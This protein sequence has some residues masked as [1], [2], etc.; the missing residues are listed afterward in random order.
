M[1][2]TGDTAMTFETLTADEYPLIPS[3][4]GWSVQFA[5]EDLLAAINTVK[6]AAEKGGS[7]PTLNSILFELSQ[8]DGVSFGKIVAADGF[9]LVINQIGFIG[10]LPEQVVKNDKRE[11]IRVV[12]RLS[13]IEPLVKLLAV[14]SETVTM[15]VKTEPKHAEQV[16]FATPTWEVVGHNDAITYPPY[17]DIVPKSSLNSFVFTVKASDLI[18]AAE[19]CLPIA[20]QGA[21]VVIIG[22]EAGALTLQS[23]NGTS[24]IKTSV[25]ATITGEPHAFAVNCQYLIEALQVSPNSIMRLVQRDWTQPI[26]IDHNGIYEVIMPM[27]LEGQDEPKP[28]EDVTSDKV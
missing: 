28:A 23:S 25:S 24:K 10:T 15:T 3:L 13:A 22:S 4:E 18:S 27:R 12:V 17:M 5:S 2:D 6:H 16:S 19:K 8:S 21:N 7:R 1:F 11:P 26:R 14:Q 20:K 9:R